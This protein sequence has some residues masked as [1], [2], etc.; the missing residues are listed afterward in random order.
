MKKTYN[1]PIAEIRILSGRD[2]IA[3]S[4]LSV[5]GDFDNSDGFDFE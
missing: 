1:S 4:A 3:L 2:V 5:A